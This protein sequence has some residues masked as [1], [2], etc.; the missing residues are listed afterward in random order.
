MQE[1][2]DQPAA[3]PPPPEPTQNLSAECLADVQKLHPSVTLDD[4]GN[5]FCTRCRN[6]GCERSGLPV[7]PTPFPRF[8]PQWY[9]VYEI[10]T[11]KPMSLSGFGPAPEVR[12]P[13]NL[14]PEEP[15]GN[16][17]ELEAELARMETEVDQALEQVQRGEARR[18]VLHPDP[19]VRAMV[20]YQLAPHEVPFMLG[21]PDEEVRLAAVRVC[22]CYPA[23]RALVVILR[24]GR[25]DPSRKVREGVAA[26]LQASPDRLR[27]AFIGHWSTEAAMATTPGYPMHEARSLHDQGWI[28]L[29]AGMPRLPGG[30]ARDRGLSAAW[31]LGEPSARVLDHNRQAW[32]GANEEISRKQHGPYAVAEGPWPDDVVAPEEPAAPTPSP[33]EEP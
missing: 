28:G 21:D 12:P 7:N 20:A 31:A 14:L 22:C 15:D 25:T 26:C 32:S 24:I 16:E 11:C 5:L 6:A 30:S 33:T 27:Q 8:T 2:K 9:R 18:Y 10:G 17:A 13:R 4:L 23:L 19:R 1:E 29:S 3:G